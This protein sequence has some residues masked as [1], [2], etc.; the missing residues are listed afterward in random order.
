MGCPDFFWRS[1]MPL[2]TLGAATTGTPG[3]AVAPDPTPDAQW[4]QARN[5]VTEQLSRGKSEPEVVKSLVDGGWT[6]EQAA[7]F[8]RDAATALNVP[9]QAMLAQGAPAAGPSGAM[10]DIAMHVARKNMLVGGIWL[11]L[12][13]VVTAGTYA[14]ASNGGGT[15][16]VTWGAIVFGGIQFLKGVFQFIGASGRR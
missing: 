15:Y 1:A 2:E 8:V 7:P 13:I 3:T 10:R 4:Q 9:R 12:G 14:A 6:Q 11:V 16:V 5:Y